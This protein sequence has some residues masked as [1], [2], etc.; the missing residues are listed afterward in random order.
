MESGEDGRAAGRMPGV[1]EMDVVFPDGN[2][3]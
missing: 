2:K 1:L 3:P